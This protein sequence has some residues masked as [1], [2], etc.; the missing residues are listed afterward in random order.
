MWTASE[1]AE[2]FGLQVQTRGRDPVL[3]GSSGWILIESEPGFWQT[4]SVVKILRRR[5]VRVP[6]GKAAVE[7]MVEFRAARVFAEHIDEAL[8]GELRAHKVRMTVLPADAAA[9]AE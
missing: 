7:T 9:A 1:L 6:V 8:E 3:S 2:R 5:G 4:I